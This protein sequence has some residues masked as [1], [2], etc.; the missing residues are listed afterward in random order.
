MYNKNCLVISVTF[1]IANKINNE[2]TG[3][4]LGPLYRSFSKLFVHIWTA[5]A[6][7]PKWDLLF[8]FLCDARPDAQ[9]VLN[10]FLSKAASYASSHALRKYVFR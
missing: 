6:V 8:L 7:D 3:R 10:T 1:I 9:R 2:S 4:W 5:A